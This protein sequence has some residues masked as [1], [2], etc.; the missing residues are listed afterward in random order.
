MKK[1]L[2][3]DCNREVPIQPKF[4]KKESVNY[5]AMSAKEFVDHIIVTARSKQ[6]QKT[7]VSE[8]THAA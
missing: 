5:A 8:T 6:R 3:I 4:G 2:K 1:K 7:Q